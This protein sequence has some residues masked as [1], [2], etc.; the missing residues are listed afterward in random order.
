[1]TDMA[2]PFEVRDLRFEIDDRVPRHWHG[3]RKSVTAFFDNLSLFFPAG[4]RF[5]V[6]SVKAHRAYVTDAELAEQVRIFCSQEGMHSREHTRYNRMLRDQG[7]PAA[8]MERRVERL[9]RHV[10]RVAPKR[11]QLAATCALEHFTALMAH[12]LLETPRMLEGAHPTMAAL[13]KWHAAEE[14]EHKTVPYDVYLASGGHYTERVAVMAVATVRFWAKVLEHQVR[15]MRADGTASSPREWWALVHF[16]FVDPGGMA[17]VVGKY[18]AY[19]RP[20]FHPSDLDS[21]E[22]I[23]AWKHELET[24]PL[25]RQK[26]VSR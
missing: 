24:S 20:S 14:N 25:Y 18:F 10:R 22:V 8:R 23:E 7:Y 12:L 17:G 19:Y 26:A 16:L 11:M 1:M 3:G 5:F 9:L 15:L 13:W 2:S 4:E 6:A 21:H